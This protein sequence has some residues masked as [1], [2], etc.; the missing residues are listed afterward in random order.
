[1]SKPMRDVLSPPSKVSTLPAPPSDEDVIVPPSQET[2]DRLNAK[3][4]TLGHGREL[5]VVRTAT[6]E[7]VHRVP[8]S[9]DKS[10]R[11]V[12]KVM[13]GMLINMADEFHVED[14][15]DDKRATSST[16]SRPLRIAPPKRPTSVLTPRRS[17]A[18]TG[19]PAKTKTGTW[20][21]LRTWA[22]TTCR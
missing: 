3:A 10:D 11:Q 5:R 13:S 22:R 6:R 7:V 8:I 1:M 2:M 14:S 4:V 17:G 12:E 9:A 15:A 21:A 18:G 19:S 20:R 16:S